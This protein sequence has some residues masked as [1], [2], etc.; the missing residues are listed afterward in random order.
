NNTFQKIPTFFARGMAPLADGVW[1]V[2]IFTIPRGKFK[3][4]SPLNP[5]RRG[6][7]AA[8][9]KKKNFFEQCT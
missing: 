9:Q 3:K 8:E 5:L 7:K 2:P 1:G 4:S 6:G